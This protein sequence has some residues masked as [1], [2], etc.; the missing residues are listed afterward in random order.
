VKLGKANNQLPE[1]SK[2]NLFSGGYLKGLNHFLTLEIW[3]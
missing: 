3:F 2:N 1:T